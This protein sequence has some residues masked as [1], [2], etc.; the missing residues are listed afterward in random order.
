MAMTNPPPLKK[1]RKRHNVFFKKLVWF[2]IFVQT[3]LPFSLAFTPVMLARAD[4][5]VPD[6]D[7]THPYTL[8]PGESVQ[9]VAK[10]YNLSVAQLKKVNQFRIFSHAFETLHAGEEID[11]PDAPLQKDPQ[12]VEN[13][14][15]ASP[16][17]NAELENWL[18]SGASG[19]ASSM[20]GRNHP[21]LSDIAASRVRSSVVS[22]SEAAVSQYL[23]QFG[24]V[25]LQLGVADDLGLSESSLDMLV[26]VYDKGD[27]LW[28]MQAGGRYLNKRTTLNLGTGL[29]LFNGK[30][31]YGANTFYDDDVTGHNR[32]AGAGAELWTDY[33]RFSGNI[34]HRLS[35]WHAS[36]FIVDY[37]ERP[38]NGFDATISGWLPAYPQL[39]AKLKY[40]QY[41]GDEVALIND[42][43]RQRNPRAVTAGVDYTPFPFMTI[44][45]EYRKSGGKSDMQV[46]LQFKWTPGISLAEQFSPDAVA[47]GKTLAGSRLELVERNNNIVLEYKKQELIKLALPEYVEGVE[48]SVQTL[49]V[50]VTSKYGL[51]RIDWQLPPGFEAAGGAMMTP[52]AGIYQ[53]KLP[54]RK[55]DAPDHYDITGVAWDQKGNASLPVRMHVV[56]DKTTISL[57]R[58]SLHLETDQSLFADGKSTHKVTF[59]ALDD[60]GTPVTGLVPSIAIKGVFTPTASPAPPVPA[61]GKAVAMLSSV[62]HTVSEMIIPSAHAEMTPSEQNGGIRL[63][64]FTETAA[65]VYEATLTSG[66]IP[67][68][69]Q[70]SLGVNDNTLAPLKIVFVD[71]SYVLGAPRKPVTP[72]VADNVSVPEV[73]MPVTDKDGKPVANKTFTLY[74]DSDPQQ[75]TTDANGDITVELPTKSV[76]GNYSFDVHSDSSDVTVVV[77]YT[78]AAGDFSRSALSADNTEILAD[79]HAKTTITLLLKDASEHPISGQTVLF[80]ATPSTDIQF[81]SVTDHGDGTY[82][83]EM[84]GAQAGRVD[85]TALAGGAPVP[86]TPVSILLVQKILMIFKQNAPLQGNPVVGD[87]LKVIAQCT[88]I[89]TCTATTGYS[90]EV[91]TTPGSGVWQNIK[92]AVTDEYVVTRDIQKR[93]IRVSEQSAP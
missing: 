10:R 93:R 90:W 22:G 1:Y 4:E 11:V 82:S 92:D 6:F 31:M 16:Q 36:R 23:N 56:V 81:S 85:V 84:R 74:V 54:L 50:R 19:L 49:N 35:N 80:T 37:D 33:L 14:S 63:S 45:S 7:K 57:S 66:V 2:N 53:M 34:Y 61:K 20:S 38:A 87:V 9:S 47:A 27:A 3:M 5:A 42:E 68:E 75:V 12:P 40:E 60:N 76:P 64:D 72:V 71:E 78:P 67:G 41:Y 69:F 65:G 43:E 17:Q 52:D 24:T 13:H 51:D 29:R 58:S 62:G 30:W 86:V 8:L 28:F 18:A 59:T 83:A 26:P 25:K 32:R 77:T 79:S 15:A 91:E 39:G 89:S 46:N 70:L 88:N 48:G 44:G 73:V 55:A 21:A